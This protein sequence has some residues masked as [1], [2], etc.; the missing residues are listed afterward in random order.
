MARKYVRDFARQ[1]VKAAC[2]RLGYEYVETINESNNPTQQTWVSLEFD[3][4]STTKATFCG[5]T[6]ESGDIIIVVGSAPG[7]GDST[8]LTAIEA[9]ADDVFGKSDTSGRLALVSKGSP[10]EATPNDGSPTYWLEL[11]IS[12]ELY[13]S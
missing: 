13:S 9:I 8:A 7:M 10:D 6:I 11:S 12:Y 2:T 1:W 3:T 5:D 4:F